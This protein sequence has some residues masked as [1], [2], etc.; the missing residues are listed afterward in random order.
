MY[1]QVTPDRI[2]EVLFSPGNLK[3]L[4]YAVRYIDSNVIYVSDVVYGG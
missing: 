2:N 1:T 3:K 4:L